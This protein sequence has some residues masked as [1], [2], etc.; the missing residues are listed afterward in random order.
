MSFYDL[1]LIAQIVGAIVSLAGTAYAVMRWMWPGML[2][3]GRALSGLMEIGSRSA[4]LLTGLQRTADVE[5]LLKQVKH[6]V[7]P[8]GGTSLRDAVNRTEST[9]NLLVGQMRAHAD[10]DDDA[11]RLDCDSEG[12][13]EWMARALMTWTERT[14]DDLKGHGWIS[15][16][17]PDDRE[18]VAEEYARCI[19]HRRQFDV[20]FRLINRRGDV[21]M[22]RMS[23][24]PVATR[25]VGDTETLRWVGTLRRITSIP[26]SLIPPERTHR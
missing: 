23:C 22:V 17:H 9:V 15:S 6:E 10:A 14:S 25:R 13:V 24:A 16:I 12:R 18:D 8:N 20:A 19:R 4:D 1:P 11:A 5:T 26:D 2:R 3:T 21:T 7:M